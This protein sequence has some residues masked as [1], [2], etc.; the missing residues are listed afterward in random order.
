MYI[1]DEK[2]QLALLTDRAQGGP[3]RFTCCRLRVPNRCV[4]SKGSRLPLCQLD[5]LNAQARHAGIMLSEH[6]RP[7][8]L[9]VAP[10]CAAGR[11][12]SWCTGA[13]WK[14]GRAHI[15]QQCSVLPLTS[16]ACGLAVHLRL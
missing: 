16:A 5:M 2:R 7:T 8:W 12:R 15:C 1:Q 9:Q 3:A 13:P 10:L 6:D 14:V 11:W 4:G